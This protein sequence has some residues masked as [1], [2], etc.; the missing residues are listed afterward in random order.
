M[1]AAN[2]IHVHDILEITNIGQDEIFLVSGR[3]AHRLI[4]RNSFDP[5]ICCSQQFVRAILYPT[6]HVGIGWAAVGRVVLESSILGWI[7]RRRNHDAVSEM[8][9]ATTVVNQNRSRDNRR[10]SYPV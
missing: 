7:M 3:G 6:G 10:G 5:C 4:K 1:S 2:R 9:L 8:L